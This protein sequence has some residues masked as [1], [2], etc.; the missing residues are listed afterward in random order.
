MSDIRRLRSLKRMS[1]A[2]SER[3]RNEDPLRFFEKNTVTQSGLTYSDLQERLD[4]I[5]ECAS[6]LEL[7]QQWTTEPD[8]TLEQSFSVS[9]A[10]YCKQH[11]I[12]PVCADRLQARRRARFD[13]SI[14]S[15]AKLVEATNERVIDGN[16][17]PN[18]KENR[19]AY[20]VTYTVTDTE[21]LAGRLE[22]LKNAKRAFRRM[23]QK[24]KKIENSLEWTRST[25]EAGKITAAIS[26]IEIKRGKNSDLWHVHS[27][28]L[29]FTDQPI[30]YEV[31]DRTARNNLRKQYGNNIPK[32]KLSEIALHPVEFRGEVVP[33]SKISREWLAAT[34]GDSI[35]IRIDRLEHVPRDKTIF[36][37]GILKKKRIPENKRMQLRKMSFE[38]SLSYQSKEVLKYMSKPGENSPGD[39]LEIISS[40]YNKRMVATYGQFRGV[41]GDD[42]SDPAD[43]GE[44]TYVMTWD[45]ARAKYGDP[46]LGKLRDLVDAEAE[47]NTRSRCGKITGTY[48]RQRKELMEAAAVHG[49]D[50]SVLMDAAKSNYR[51]HIGSVWALYRSTV[52]TANRQAAGGCDKYSAVLT[53]AGSWFPATD[54]RDM[55]HAAFSV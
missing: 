29:V 5:E 44:D 30:D 40:T 34:N 16:Y 52:D 24:R 49:T 51:S 38:D 28:D 2:F 1:V 45:A 31:Y 20:I 46:Q 47:H 25:G 32:D 41:A 55:I 18:D 9:A 37:N 15:Q 6:I 54:Y 33:S 26:T 10:N 23:G 11:A 12:C 13:K 19:F 48:R 8:G 27:H 50:L 43:P 3:V 21:D 7:K 35:G 22:H 4:K 17:L 42:Y 14:R 39:S 53:P 36:E